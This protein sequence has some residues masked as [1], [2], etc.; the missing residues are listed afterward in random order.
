MSNEN[1]GTMEEIVGREFKQNCGDTLI[2]NFKSN[3][4]GYQ[5]KSLYNCTFKKYPISLEFFKRDILRGSC[6]NPEIERIEFIEKEWNQKCGD[7][8]HIIKKS[9]KK[10]N[11]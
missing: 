8:I 1:I 3:N 9:N 7:I 6:I 11:N 2:V 10:T 4:K 5:N